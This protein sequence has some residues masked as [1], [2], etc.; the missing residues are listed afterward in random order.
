MLIKF[1][2]S[3][4]ASKLQPPR[5]ELITDI[6][7]LLIV[8]SKPL[9]IELMNLSTHSSYEIFLNNPFLCLSAIACCAIY[10]FTLVAPTPIS[11]AKYCTSKHSADWTFKEIK[12]RRFCLIKWWWTELVTNI[13]GR[14]ILVL[15]IS[16]SLK[17]IWTYPSL[18]ACSASRFILE[19]SISKLFSGF[20][21]SIVVSII[22][23][24]S[25]IYLRI[26]LNCSIERTGE[27]NCKWS[28][29]S[30]SSSRILLKFPILVR[31]LITTLSLNESIGGFVTWLK[32]CLKKWWSPLYL[33]ESTANGVS[34]PIDPV[35]SFFSAIIGWSINSMSSTDQAK[36]AIL[37]LRSPESKSL[38]SSSTDWTSLSIYVI[39]LVQSPNGL[40]SAKYFFISWSLKNFFSLKLT[41]INWPGPTLPLST[42]SF[43]L[44]STIP[45][46]EP[47]MRRFFVSVYLIGLR[48]F[49]SIP[50]MAQSPYAPHIA[51]GPSHGS[52]TAPP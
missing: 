41:A 8:L 12:V 51:A 50:A 13:I 5:Y 4:I 10:A 31:R 17:I 43:S 44:I 7:I 9:F 35:A 23:T 11:T 40:V 36:H 25:F 34:S 3:P 37:F 14:A 6:P 28:H 49:L 1:L 38:N 29:W 16:L 26:D 15:D 2:L 33:F 27:F 20:V 46:S 39:F 47:A 32:F 18:T 24:V 48:P 22:F 19:I 52:I 42:I 30:S 21:L 45:V